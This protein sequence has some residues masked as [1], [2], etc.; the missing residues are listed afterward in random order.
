MDDFLYLLLGLAWVGWSLYSNKQKMD[1]KRAAQAEQ[2][3]SAQQEASES[4]DQPTVPPPIFEPAQPRNILEELF[5]DQI[6]R[7]PEAEEE[8]YIP[9]VDEQSWERKM[10]GY[11]KNEAESLEEIREEVPSD[12]FAKQYA[13]RHNSQNQRVTIEEPD[14]AEVSDAE[15]L[16]HDF[17]LKRAVIFSEVLRAPY[18]P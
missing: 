4:W 3:R 10:S 14:Y 18:I 6:P 13:A 12:Y 5:G 2:Q 8:V 9:D 16:Q 17:D 7:Q 11:K 15:E 1:R